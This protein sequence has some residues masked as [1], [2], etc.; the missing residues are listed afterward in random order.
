MNIQTLPLSK[1]KPA[2]YNPRSSTQKQ[3]EHLSA[4]LTKFGVVEPIIYNEQ[5]GY[6][7][8]GHFRVRELKKLGFKEIECVVVDL[9]PEDEREL[10][11][12][13]N[14]NT[15]G[16]D[17]DELANNWDAQKLEDWGL[18]LPFDNIDYSEKNKEIDIDDLDSE[19]VIKL[20]YTEEEYNIV[21]EQLYKIAQSP[22]QAVWKL[23]GNE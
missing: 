15:G 3:E 16:W 23:L 2:P 8:G 21:K 4:S 9:S 11:I 19:M 14:A 12:R 18:D 10:N 22:E 13:L 1:L 20:K 17:W 5:T 6:I 7:V